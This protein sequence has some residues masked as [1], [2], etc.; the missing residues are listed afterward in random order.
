MEMETAVRLRIPVIVVV[1]NNDGNG[2]ALTQR[3]Y[4]PGSADPITMFGP[5]IH[6]DQMM[7]TFGGHG[8]YVDRAEEIKPALAR[9]VESG[10]PACINVRVDPDSPYPR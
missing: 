7:A 3:A 2:G 8:E 6:Y 5:G 9:A 10:M 1:A 4:Y